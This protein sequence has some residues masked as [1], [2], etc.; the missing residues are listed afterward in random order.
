MRTLYHILQKCFFI[1]PILWVGIYLNGCQTNTRK[2]P[3]SSA[4]PSSADVGKLSVDY[5]IGFSFS[6]ENNLTW[7][8][9]YSSQGDTTIYLL[10]PKGEKAPEVG[11]S[12]TTIAVPVENI[13]LTSTA[14][15]AMLDFL[16]AVDKI[17]GIA[18]AD[19]VQNEKVL[20]SLENGSML[21][22]GKDLDLN[23]E[24]VLSATP[25]LVTT[26]GA[27]DLPQSGM[28]VLAET[29]VH[30]LP[31]L[32]WQET[33]LLAR[34]EW[35]KVFAALLGEEEIVDQKFDLMADRYGKL[36]Q[37]TDS[38]PNQPNVLYGTPYKGVWYVP[39]AKSFVAHMLADAGANY[40]WSTDSSA[41][42]L[43]LALEAVYEEALKAD[44]WLVSGAE[45]NL[46]DLLS[47]DE[48]FLDFRPAKLKMVYANNLQMK[49]GG[50][51]N[52]YEKGIMEPDMI[53][54]DLIK[55]LHPESLPEHSFQYYR[56]LE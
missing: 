16:G 44:F 36:A 25:E 4:L 13:M 39:G 26:V 46:K 54:A 31:I 45:L 19:F 56:K 28:S 8:S 49:E 32:E 9:L 34:A 21:N 33:S 55:L 15:V 37:L 24:L 2:A 17:K 7:L 5:A 41:I 20:T 38:L 23:T 48:R 53:L 47:I 12:I 52:I 29:G 1:L 10:H 22:I 6:Y 51:N 35:V 42:T 43:P 14:H 18:N 11:P 3:P 27:V 30:I 40:A 50:G